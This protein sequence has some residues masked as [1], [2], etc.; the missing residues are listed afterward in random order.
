MVHRLD[1]L[2]LLIDDSGTRQA[3]LFLN[4]NSVAKWHQHCRDFVEI[5]NAKADFGAK[6]STL[7]LSRRSHGATPLAPARPNC[8]SMIASARSPPRRE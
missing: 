2:R 8:Q 6:L 5:P 4:L 7:S 1:D 3:V